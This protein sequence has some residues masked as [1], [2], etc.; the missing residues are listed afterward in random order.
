VPLEPVLTVEYSHVES[1]SR[2]TK[3]VSVD[4]AGRIKKVAGTQLYNGMAK[5]RT[6]TGSPTDILR[7]LD[8]AFVPLG[9]NEC[10]ICAPPPAGRD[11]WQIRTAD[12]LDETPGAIA[13]SKDNF[14]PASG[15]AI[16]MLDVDA[17]DFSKELHA[18]ISEIGRFSDVL[19]SVFRPFG[20]AARLARRST[21]SGIKFKSA[22]TAPPPTGQHLYFV[23]DDG[24]SIKN[25]VEILAKRLVLAGFGWVK[26][27]A[28]GST[29]HRTLFDEFASKDVSRLVYEADAVIESELLEYAKD[30]RKAIVTPGG[31]LPLSKIEPLT[32]DEQRRYEAIIADQ[33]RSA[34]PAAAKVREEYCKGRVQE[35]EARGMSLEDAKHAV[36][37]AV[38]R[39]ELS[40][41]WRLHL[42]DGR[43]ISVR[44]IW[45]TRRHSIEKHA[46]I[47]WS[48]NT[49][50]AATL[51]SF[52]P[53]T[54]R[55]TFRAART[56]G[57]NTGSSPPSRTFFRSWGLSGTSGRS[58][59]S[60]LASWTRSPLQPRMR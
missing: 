56:A 46:P 39:H 41:E 23:V 32:D 51:R 38:E 24:E 9:P 44:E 15:A 8:A 16:L 3:T 27:S 48:P 18:K 35:L 4:E 37:G 36:A 31:I 5:R 52:T 45:T 21:S 20:S 2:L 33:K 40:P 19:T 50:A 22:K 14:R 55:F 60:S 29:L 26:I 58:L 1:V 13:R 7:Q 42:D 17:A 11:E 28:S 59:K 30:A 54:G 43:G 47:R 25:A 34:K 12:K 49:T 10:V 53:T 6:L 57:S